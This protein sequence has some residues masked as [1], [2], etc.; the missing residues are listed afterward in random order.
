MVDVV[1]VVLVVVVST[2]AMGVSVLV[3]AGEGVVLTGFNLI[4][5]NGF[6]EVDD[7]IELGL[8]R[9]SAS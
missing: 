6:T 1:V 4:L 8:A 9:T 3:L 5:F 2:T 7:A